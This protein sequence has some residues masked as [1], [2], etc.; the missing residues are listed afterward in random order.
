MMEMFEKMSKVERGEEK[1]TKKLQRRCKEDIAK[2]HQCP[3]SNCHR[4][5]STEA[6]LQ[7]HIKLK[8]K[9]VKNEPP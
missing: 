2:E 4:F 1:H 7:R 5:Y 3:H 9:I 6:T 8:H